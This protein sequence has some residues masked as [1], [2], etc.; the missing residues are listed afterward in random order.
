[1]QLVLDVDPLAHGEI[2]ADGSRE[3]AIRI[4]ASMAESWLAW[5]SSLTTV[6]GSDVLASEDD[7]E[8]LPALLDALAYI[9]PAGQALSDVLALPVCRRWEDGLQVA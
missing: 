6:I 5:G 2:G 1:M 7:A 4:A 3:W 9:L 8:P